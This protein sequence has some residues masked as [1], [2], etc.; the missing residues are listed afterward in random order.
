VSRRTAVVTGSTSGIGAAVA[1]RLQA[2][3]FNVVVT[4]RDA[5][6][7]AA[8]VDELGSRSVFVPLDLV[9]PGAPGELADA[10]VD[11][12]GRLDVIVNNAARD[13]TGVLTDVPLDDVRAVF[14]TNVLAAIAVLQE[15]AKRMTNG[16]SIINV[17]SRLASIGIPTMGI[18]GAA[19]G[20]LKTL[21]TAAAIELAH[22]NIRVN[23]V[24][25]GQTRTPL[26]DAWL[27]E[28][29]D[30][31]SVERD[32]IAGIPL[33]RLAEPADVAAVVSFLASDDAAYLTGVSIPVDGGYTAH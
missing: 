8:L 22:R 12:F 33:G 5:A 28:Q 17:T 7:G 2:D 11:T 20:A 25:P 21:T 31:A 19:K 6:R 23:A 4:G 10:A 9:L 30:P 13:H 15:G 32:V 18:Y 24:A 16:G 14:E 29:A 26:Y 27:R 3:G 1:R